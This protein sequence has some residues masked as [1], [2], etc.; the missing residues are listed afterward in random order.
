MGFPFK[1]LRVS[2]LSNREERTTAVVAP[3]GAADCSKR[4]SGTPMCRISLGAGY[5]REGGLENRRTPTR[6]APP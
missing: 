1:V 4:T 6:P 2:A 5:G 3:P